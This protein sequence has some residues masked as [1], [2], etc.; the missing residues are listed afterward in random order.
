MGTAELYSVVE[1]IDGVVRQPGRP[2]GGR[3]RGPGRLVLLVVL[4]RNRRSCATRSNM[5]LGQISRP[6]HVPDEIHLFRAIPRT[7]SGKKLELPVKRILAG[8]SPADVASR[9]ALSD[10][11]RSTRSRSLLD[12]ARGAGANRTLIRITT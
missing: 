5:H 8:E 10:P 3:R 1:D 2:S 6:R 9:D 7:L 11:R 12:Q 4:R